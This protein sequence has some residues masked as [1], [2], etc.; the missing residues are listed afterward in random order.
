[1]PRTQKFDAI[2]ERRCVPCGGINGSRRKWVNVAYTVERVGDRTKRV[3]EF[4]H[5]SEPGEAL[6]AKAHAWASVLNERAA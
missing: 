3:R 2:L 5:M 4:L 6:L 1:M